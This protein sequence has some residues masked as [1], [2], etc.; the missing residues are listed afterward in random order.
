MHLNTG[1]ISVVNCSDS[2]ITTA[3]YSMNYIP[4]PATWKARPQSEMVQ[5]C[6]SHLNVPLRT[7]HCTQF[8]VSGTAVQLC[9]SCT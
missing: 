2:T 8:A 1:T 3:K 5:A 9:A 4:P 7:Q 6:T